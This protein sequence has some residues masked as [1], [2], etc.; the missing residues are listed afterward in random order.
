VTMVTGQARQKGLLWKPKH[1]KKNHN[2]NRSFC[3]EKK[4]PVFYSCEPGWRRGKGTRFLLMKPG[5][6]SGL[7]TMRGLR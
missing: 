2:K 3:K 4:K 6:D 7:D 1:K 5:F